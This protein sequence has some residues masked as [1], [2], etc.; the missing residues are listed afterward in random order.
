MDRRGVLRRVGVV[1]LIPG[2]GCVGSQSPGTRDSPTPDRGR[3]VTIVSRAGQPDAPIQYD[4]RMGESL[5]T[6]EHPARLRIT[7]R[8]PT[9]QRVVIGEE[10]AVKFHHVSST[11]QELYLHPTGGEAPVM[12]GCWQLTE[13]VAVAEYY[14][15]ISIGAGES[16]QADS[17]VYGHQNLPANTCLPTGDHQVT[18]SGIAGRDEDTVL[19][20]APIDEFEWGFRLR[21]E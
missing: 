16:I 14:G 2:A 15:T 8:N 7:I 17:V 10:R 3:T 21:I 12:D 9:E 1:L 4:A 11:N 20:G 5:A 19:E 6:D 13:P 18:T